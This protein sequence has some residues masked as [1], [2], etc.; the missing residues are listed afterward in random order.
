MSHSVEVYAL[1]MV[2]R[3]F[4]FDILLQMRNVI[5]TWV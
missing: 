1:R 3:A 5:Q 4:S 2:R